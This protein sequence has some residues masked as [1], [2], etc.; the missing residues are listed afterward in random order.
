MLTECRLADIC[1]TDQKSKKKKKSK[2]KGTTAPS[3]AVDAP[4]IAVEPETPDPGDE[5]ETKDTA[6]KES[7]D[8]ELEDDT[9]AS[10]HADS[11]QESVNEP[12]PI[13][14]KEPSIPTTEETSSA[15]LTNGDARTVNET[16]KSV[17]NND[18]AAR[19]DALVK[20]RDALR[21]EV[22]Q[23]RQSLEELRSKHATD[24]ETVRSELAE[25]QAEKESAEEQYQSLLGKVNTIRSQLGERLKA[26]AEDLAQART[27]IDELEE[28]KSELQE[29]YTARSAEVEEL[30][31]RNQDLA[32]K[33]A[34][35]SKELST[36]RN[37]LTLAQQNW[38]KER[39]ELVDQE[40]YLREEF[41]SAKQA[42]H[43]WEVLAM[44]ER[45]MRR[46]LADR[47]VDLEEQVSALKEAYEKAASERDTQT[48]TVDGLQRALQ[49]IQSVRKQE[50]KE[51]VEANQ[52]EQEELRAQL[53]ELQTKH[54]TT[55]AELEQT[56]KELER[57]LP[58]EKEVKEK[59]LLIGKLRHEAVILNDHL[60]KA[61]R[62]L[63]KGKPEDNVDRQIVTNHFLQFLALDRADPKKFQV[64][65]LIAA[66][67]GWTDEQREQAGLARPG[68]HG[69]SNT[70][71]SNSNSLRLPGSP[72]FHRTPST[73]ALHH[74][75]FGPDS[76]GVSSPGASS[77][78]KES[79]AEL[80]Q[81]FLE[82]EAG[83]SANKS[84]KTG[85]SR[86]S[87]QSTTIP[88]P[89]PQ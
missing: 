29:R 63:K 47:N 37:R 50:L 21:L 1:L 40:A 24:I 6:E 36:L 61:L 54:D 44:E 38:L 11:K 74:E 9:K 57:A 46:D 68:G 66:L 87:S 43:D 34:E 62:F 67:L 52:K 14:E 64:L 15:A 77:A 4:T 75:Y 53:H 30:T 86:Q 26:D 13:P 20:D 10:V 42:M 41:E 88:P 22:T 78:S 82:Q 25:T 33:A 31:A 80:W 28:Q 58:F 56:K 23:L 2:K 51:L 83:A 76:L 19:F 48:N 3:P 5:L 49:E 45:T 85:N 55:V 79:L 59:N 16:E 70:F 65:Q 27:Q 72:L 89:T 32:T 60:T 84:T 8:T 39:E 18:A 69:S 71:A 73:P 12:E 35:Q 17:D 81:H 7:E